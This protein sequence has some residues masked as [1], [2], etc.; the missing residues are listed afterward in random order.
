MIAPDVVVVHPPG[1][2]TV[3]T[4]TGA[5]GA[6]VST[7][8]RAH[9]DDHGPVSHPAYARTRYSYAPVVNTPAGTVHA[10]VAPDVD[11]TDPDAT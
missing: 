1:G 2:N 7:V 3:D 5:A 10:P 4:G 6:V 9:P 11:C 8:N